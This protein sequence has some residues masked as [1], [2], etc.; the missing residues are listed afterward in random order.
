MSSGNKK[1]DNNGIENNQLEFN[2][3]RTNRK[4]RH[5]DKIDLKEITFN[6]IIGWRT[7][8]IRKNSMKFRLYLDNKKSVDVPILVKM[9][10]TGADV[11]KTLDFPFSKDNKLQTIKEKGT[12]KN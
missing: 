4:G 8:G 2:K 3:N 6:D 10:D 1:G 12:K 7:V 5:G 11:G 9:S